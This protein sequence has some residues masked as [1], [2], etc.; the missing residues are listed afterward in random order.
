MELRE[1]AAVSGRSGLFKIVK[2]TKTGVILETIEASPKR[3]V[4]GASEKVSILNEIS[5]YTT[6]S[7]GS[8]ALEKVFQEIKK[9]FPSAI[10]VTGKSSPEELKGFLLK[11]LP[12]FDQERVYASDIKKLATWYTL[13]NEFHPEV[14]E[15]KVEQVPQVAVEEVP[16]KEPAKKKATKTTVEATSD[17][18]EEKPKAAKKTAAKKAAKKSAE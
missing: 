12:H 3:I 9:N 18:G 17:A 15:A 1:V 11:V 10:S 2:P 6:D 16:A 14:F 13:L 7:E 4:A 8:V 5:I